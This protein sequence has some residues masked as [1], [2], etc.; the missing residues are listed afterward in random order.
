M[1]DRADRIARLDASLAA[2]ESELVIIRENEPDDSFAELLQKADLE[3]LT[4]RLRDLPPASR[5]GERRRPRPTRML[6]RASEQLAE[7]EKGSGDAAA[8]S[9]RGG[10]PGAQLAAA[11]DRYVPLLFA[12]HLLQQAIQRFERESQPE[13]LREVSRIF[14]SMT[15]S[16]YTR[17]DRPVA[18]SA[19]LLIHRGDDESLEPGQLSTGTREQ[20]YLAIRLAY[21]LHYC[22]RA[23]PLPIIMDDVLANF[24][25]DRAR[26]TLRGLGEI[27][28]RVQVIMF[29]CHPHLVSLAREVFADLRPIVIPQAG[30]TANGHRG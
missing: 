23:E 21:V 27:T 17:V 3:V 5:R 6:A 1:A 2:R 12:R 16:R 14:R 24:D 28:D 26:Q 25:D 4:A 22:G 10:F 19:P 15:G 8:A 13:M 9:G 11:V 29:T 18:E 7:L 20:L 30:S